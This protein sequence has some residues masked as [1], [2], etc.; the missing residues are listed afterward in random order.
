VAKKGM[1]SRITPQRIRQSILN[2][3]NPLRN[4]SYEKLVRQL[5]AFHAGYLGDAAR[6]WDTQ[7]RRNIYLGNVASKRKKSVARLPWEIKQTEDSREA[8]R[9]AEVLTAFY[10]SI[11]VTSVLEQ[12]E[13]GGLSLLIRQMMDAVGKRFAAHEIVWRFEPEGVKAEFLFCPLWWFENR[14]GRLRFLREEGLAEGEEMADGEWLVTV[15]EGIMESCSVMDLLRSLPLKDW[16]AFSEKFGMPGLLG[17]T[18]ATVDSEE[19]KAMEDAVRNFMNDWAAVVNNGGEITLVEPKS[20]GTNLPFAPLVEYCDRAI[21]ARWRGA[22]LSTISSG[23]QSEGT[24]ASLQGDETDLILED[25]AALITEALNEQ[26]DRFVIEYAFGEGTELKAY[27]KLK[28]ESEDQAEVTHKRAVLDKFL[29]D[30]TVNDV[31]ANLTD[32]KA[33]VRELNLPVNEE[34][35]EPYLAVQDAQGNPVTGDTVRD[36][37]GDIVGGTVGAKP[38]EGPGAGKNSSVDPGGQG[39]RV[40]SAA[41]EARAAQATNRTQFAEA[42]REAFRPIAVELQRILQIEN[43]AAQRVELQGLVSKMPQLQALINNDPKNVEALKAAMEAA[44]KK[45]INQPRHKK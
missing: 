1:S 44:F 15:G 30:G 34:Y 25:D 5:E 37:E 17:K 12:N 3:F 7:E 27:F 6:T 35:D 26:V 4:F 29:A 2:R 23:K 36:S 9:Q 10:N 11:R 43:Q 38:E 18:P 24:G 31:I 16:A 22:D 45:G 21:A 8:K 19:W 14:T 41:N 13:K 28:G 40:V 39:G 20:G 42:T 32:I 33:L